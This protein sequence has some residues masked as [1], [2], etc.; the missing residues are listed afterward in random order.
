MGM[1]GD[2]RRA[3]RHIGTGVRRQG[4][5]GDHHRRRGGMALM[6]GVT[7]IGREAIVGVEARRREGEGATRIVCRGVRRLGG[8]VRRGAVVLVVE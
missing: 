7:R 3:R 6:R 8:G 5:I 4:W 2:H 1:V